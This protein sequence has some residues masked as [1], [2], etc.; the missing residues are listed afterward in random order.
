MDDRLVSMPKDLIRQFLLEE[1]MPLLSQELFLLNHLKETPDHPALSCSVGMCFHGLPEVMVF[2]PNQV[3][4]CRL[5]ESLCLQKIVGIEQPIN[6]SFTDV[7][8]EHA[9]VLR[10]LTP[11]FIQHSFLKWN[12]DIQG[13]INLERV[14]QIVIADAFGRFPWD[15]FYFGSIAQPPLYYDLTK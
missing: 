9:I 8:I 6:Q 3:F 1:L 15:D 13:L 2:H 12:Q 10:Y 5:V 11:H 4:G 14:Q 7:S